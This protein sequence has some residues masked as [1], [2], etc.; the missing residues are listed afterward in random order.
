MK[1]Y[2]DMVSKWTTSTSLDKDT[3]K[4]Y[5][6]RNSSWAGCCYPEE[7]QAPPFLLETPAT[8]KLKKI[9]L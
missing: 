1:G 5:A 3:W 6:Q 8:T 2:N 9:Y 4:V 7:D